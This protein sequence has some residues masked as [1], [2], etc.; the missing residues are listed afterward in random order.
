MLHFLKYN[1]LGQV[2]LCDKLEVLKEKF[3]FG[4]PKTWIILL[5]NLVFVCTFL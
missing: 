1:I 4:L 3:Y 2:P 5:V